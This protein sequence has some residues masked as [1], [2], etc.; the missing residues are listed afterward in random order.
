MI[1]T[2][3]HINP[4][5]LLHSADGTMRIFRGYDIR[6][7]LYLHNKTAK[8]SGFFLHRTYIAGGGKNSPQTL[9]IISKVC[10]NY[11]EKCDTMPYGIKYRKDKKHDLQRE[12][13]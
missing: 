13:Y 7:M 11:I 2:K 1:F 4:T 3:M 9:E 5:A 10:Y 8:I 6:L 12:L